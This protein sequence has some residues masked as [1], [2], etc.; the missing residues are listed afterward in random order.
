MLLWYASYKD[1]PQI[2]QHTEERVPRAAVL[3]HFDDAANLLGMYDGRA[4]TGMWLMNEATE[5]EDVIRISGAVP[6]IRTRHEVYL[7]RTTAT[8]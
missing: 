8:N 5:Q 4:V 3:K 1:K 2:L 6:E 7:A